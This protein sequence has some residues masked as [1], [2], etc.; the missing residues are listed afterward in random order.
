VLSFQ[1][2]QRTR[3]FG[4]RVAIGASEFDVLGG[5]LRSGIR[6]AIIGGLI[7]LALAAAVTRLLGAFLFGVNPLDIVTFLAVPVILGIV[8]VVASYVPA[9]RATRVAPTVALRSE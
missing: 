8:A 9:R 4:I 1:V 2:A 3:E 5:V 7:G 6:L